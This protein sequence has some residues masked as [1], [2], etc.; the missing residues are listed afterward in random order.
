MDIFYLASTSPRRAELLQLMG[1]EFTCL[2]PNVIERRHHNEPLPHYVLRLAEEKALSG[3]SQISVIEQQSVV[4]GADT[5]VSWQGE[6]LEKPQNN[7]EAQA[8]LSRLSGQTHQ[9]LT[10]VAVAGSA[11]VVK[12]LVTTEV[13]FIDLTAQQIQHYIE[14]GEPMDKA[15]SYG[16]QGRGGAFVRKIDGSYH[17]VMGLPLAETAELIADYHQLS[18]SH[19][20]IHYVG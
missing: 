1:Y 2:R 12:R 4:L 8:M 5:I 20:E 17:A 15:G 6:A 14:T 11:G 9:V 3:L 18:A 19:S 10:A 16:I 7:A 13:T